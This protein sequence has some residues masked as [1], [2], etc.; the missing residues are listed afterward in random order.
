LF[1]LVVLELPVAETGDL[2]AYTRPIR[3]LDRFDLKAEEVQ[4]LIEVER[5]NNEAMSTHLRAGA[6]NLMSQPQGSTYEYIEGLLARAIRRA[7]DQPHPH[8]IIDWI[9][10]LVGV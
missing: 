2:L 4:G 9:L 3:S 6:G 10:R 8:S 7:N 1:G 5:F